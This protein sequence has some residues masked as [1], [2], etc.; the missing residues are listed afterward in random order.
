MKNYTLNQ[1]KDKIIKHFQEMDAQPDS[2]RCDGDIYDFLPTIG[3]TYNDDTQY[4]KILI[5]F[6]KQGLIEKTGNGY[7]L[8]DIGRD[9][10]GFEGVSQDKTEKR[11]VSEAEFMDN[12]F[13][14]FYEQKGNRFWINNIL[15]TYN[16]IPEPIVKSGIQNLMDQ[17]LII[18]EIIGWAETQFMHYSI[19]IDGLKAMNIHGSYTKLI[20]ANN[21]IEKIKDENI[22]LQNEKLKYEKDIRGLEEQL[23]ILNLIKAYWWFILLCV[24]FGITLANL[25]GF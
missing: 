22:H 8:T 25:L 18:L 1:Q 13:G 7:I 5:S 24:G 3:L 17:N 15:A 23:K 10:I 21:K 11:I 9:F 14:F 16:G 19:S 2:F 6:I 12:L 4:D 20:E